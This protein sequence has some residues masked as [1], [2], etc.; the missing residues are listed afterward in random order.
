MASLCCPGE[1]AGL[2]LTLTSARFF[3]GKCSL[4][5]KRRKEET[6]DRIIGS[7]ARRFFVCP[8]L[9]FSFLCS[10]RSADTAAA[11]ASSSS[12]SSSWVF[13][14]L[15]FLLFLLHHHHHFLFAR[16]EAALVWIASG[17]DMRFSDVERYRWSFLEVL[18]SIK[19]LL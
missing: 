2:G 12:S 19:V 7:R 10:L 8:S 15:R 17:L 14:F 5:E 13:C 9:F 16:I 1:I 3:R 11:A 6:V 4:R 18:L